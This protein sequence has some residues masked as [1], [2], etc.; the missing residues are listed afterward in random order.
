MVKVFMYDRGKEMCSI[1]PLRST[2][3]NAISGSFSLNAGDYRRK[4]T[5]QVTE[6]GIYKVGGGL[7]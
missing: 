2:A 7:L 4:R 6:K 3:D 5:L 1:D